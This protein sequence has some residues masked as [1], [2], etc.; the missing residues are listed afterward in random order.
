M[1][2]STQGM[3]DRLWREQESEDKEH[4]RRHLAA[5]FRGP[6]TCTHHWCLRC[7]ACRIRVPRRTMAGGWMISTLAIE[8]PRH[9]DTCNACIAE[10][11]LICIGDHYLVP[12]R[13]GEDA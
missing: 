9:A 6:C 11:G 7:I 2:E 4:Y 1:S 5:I 10:H 8:C 13:L 3:V 12:F